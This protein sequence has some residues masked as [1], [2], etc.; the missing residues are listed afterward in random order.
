MKYFLHDTNAFQDEKITELF[1]GFGYEGVGLFYT[2]LEKLAMQ[3]KPIK[4]EVLKKQLFVGKKL[5]KCWKFLESSALI[6]SNN[7]ETFN[8]NL[9][10]FSEKFQIKKEKNRERI[11]KWR[12]NQALSE[13]VT[14]YEQVCNKPKDNISKVNRI[15]DNNKEVNA[16]LSPGFKD[17]NSDSLK[18]EPEKPKEKSSAKKE[19]GARP[20]ADQISF[21]DNDTPEL[22]AKWQEWIEYKKLVGSSYKTQN[23]EQAELNKIKKYPLQFALYTIQLAIDKEWQGVVNRGTPD[24]YQ[25][26]ANNPAA[27]LAGKDRTTLTITEKPET[28]PQGIKHLDPNAPDYYDRLKEYYAVSK[29]S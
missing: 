14:R 15:E 28:R 1:I 22:R 9:M 4:T 2:I 27:F 10:K 8:E 13:N 19:K 3:E 5:E 6:S 18:A 12:E 16:S 25:A 11:S 7:G 26:Y 23:G 24:D 17:K 29:A 21:E 20:W